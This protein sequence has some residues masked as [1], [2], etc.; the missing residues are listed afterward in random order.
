MYMHTLLLYLVRTHPKGL[1]RTAGMA[2]R[3]GRGRRGSR[4]LFE[5]SRTRWH[6][7][8]A[9]S[10]RRGFRV[11]IETAA[12]AKREGAC[13]PASGLIRRSQTTVV[14]SS[15]QQTRQQPR[16]EATGLTRK[17]L[18]PAELE[19]MV[20][21][22][23]VVKH[24][25][26]DP[27]LCARARDKVWALNN[28]ERLRRDEPS[29]W[30]P[31]A[32]HEE[33]PPVTGKLVSDTLAESTPQ[34]TRRGYGFWMS[35]PATQADELLLDLL[36]RCPAVRVVAEQLLGHGRL[37]EPTGTA[38]SGGTARNPFETGH[39]TRGIYCTLPRT[40]EA[41]A[42]DQPCEAGARGGPPRGGH[43]DNI[44]CA[45]APSASCLLASAYINDVPKGA[46]GLVLWPGSHRRNWR[47]HSEL[48]RGGLVRPPDR[49]APNGDSIN[50]L[51][52]QIMADSAPVECCGPTGTVI[53]WHYLVL[54][55]AGV[56]IVADSI[57]QS[58]IY[59][60]KLTPIALQGLARYRAP[61]QP[62]GRHDFST[63][64]EAQTLWAGWNVPLHALEATPPGYV[65]SPGHA[66]V[67]HPLW[68][69]KGG[70]ASL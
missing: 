2:A 10:R 22:G 28:C 21:D 34:M 41:A 64:D 31:F 59:D 11:L 25:I 33:C 68:E 65:L 53:F 63:D 52:N 3:A 14:Q 18:T 61:S 66:P 20:V 16:Q 8:P 39:G 19:Q 4:D 48:Y 23:Y 58:V 51:G 46:G 69:C 27:E 55:A 12:L 47:Y 67:L 45:D 56:N 35:S 42:T 5:G 29:T 50:D 9:C 70:G 1:L 44:Y 43:W 57:R 40:G 36:P 15:R 38:G 60:F 37:I 62:V 24:G 32:A 49:T 54:H 30:H 6:S 13:A 17:M 26:L 7:A